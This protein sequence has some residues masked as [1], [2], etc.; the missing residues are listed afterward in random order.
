MRR[1]QQQTGFTGAIGT[2][3]EPGM[4][5]VKQLEVICRQ[6]FK[7]DAQKLGEWVAAS[8][9]ERT[10][11]SSA[12]V[13][14]GGGGNQGG[15]GPAGAAKAQITNLTGNGTAT[16]S[17]DLSAAGADGFERSRRLWPHHGA[18]VR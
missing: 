2:L 17:F 1:L 8:H 11:G 7:S 14:G 12:E 9:V 15:G 3:L 5:S 13:S 18:R 10:T 4:A 16:V 6:K